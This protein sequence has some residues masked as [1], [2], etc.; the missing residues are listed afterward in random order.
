MRSPRHVSPLRGVL[1]ALAAFFLT[2]APRL[3][4]AAASGPQIRQDFPCSGCLFVPP[5]A[6][7]KP[8]PLLIVLH[9]DAPGGKNPLVSRDAAPFVQ[10]APERGIAVFAP[11]CPKEEGCAVGS[12]WQWTRGDPPAWIDKQIDSIR[13]DVSIDPDRIWIAGWS[14]GASFLGYWYPHLAQRYAAVIFAGGGMPPASA[15]CSPC[16]PPAYFLVGDKNP[17]HHLAKDLKTNVL[18]C[19]PEVTWDLLP[20]QDHAGEWRTLNRPSKVPELLDWLVKHP[21]NC[22]TTTTN[23]PAIPPSA[24]SIPSSIAPIASATKQPE[25]PS[26]SANCAISSSTDERTIPF[27]SGSLLAMVCSVLRRRRKQSAK[28][29]NALGKTSRLHRVFAPD[30]RA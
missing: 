12:F 16:S 21:R 8:A 17:L 26:K 18:A 6:L 23:T 27:M 28:R 30:K 3:T 10:A 29:D 1:L 14:G 25:L 15:T 5:T 24:L 19:T 7:A 22:P 9:G 2:L 20:G 13:K 4:V 11:K